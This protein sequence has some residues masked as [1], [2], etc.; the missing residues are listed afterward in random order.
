MD[1]IAGPGSIFTFGPDDY[2]FLGYNP[3]TERIYAAKILD[4][5]TS[6]ALLSY[7]RKA[8][9]DTKYDLSKEARF[10]FVILTSEDFDGRAAFF[11][12]ADNERVEIETIYGLIN[13]DDLTNLKSEI[14]GSGVSPD[15]KKR[16]EETWQ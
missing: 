3:S 11:G 16:V 10:H 15:I 2:I 13:E 7:R 6:D 14:L 1:K 12:R 9:R 4:Q 8:E 5:E